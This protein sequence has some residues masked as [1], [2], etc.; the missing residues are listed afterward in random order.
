MKG[1]IRNVAE[2]ARTADI[3]EEFDLHCNEAQQLHELDS[4]FSRIW[5]AYRYGV[6]WGEQLSAYN[7]KADSNAQHKRVRKEQ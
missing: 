4:E 7:R 5:Y 1:S 6:V 3:P 2:I